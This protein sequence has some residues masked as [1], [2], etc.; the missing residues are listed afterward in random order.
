MYA[1]IFWEMLAICWET[2]PSWLKKKQRPA[3]V[4]LTLNGPLK[5]S[6]SIQI[7]AESNRDVYVFLRFIVECNVLDIHKVA[8]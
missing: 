4:F 8:I 6:I 3:Y 5:T 1:V 7:K 2:N